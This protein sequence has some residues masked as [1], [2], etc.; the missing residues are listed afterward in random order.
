M[1]RICVAVLVGLLG[2]GDD[3][4]PTDASGG[5]A[6]RDGGNFALRG[7]VQK[8]PFVAGSTV[9]VAAVDAMLSPTGAVYRTMTSNDL[10]EF[11]VSVGDAPA[12]RIEG[13]GFYY[14]EATA[15][16]SASRIVL[17]A[18]YVPGADTTQSAHV[19]MIT[20]VTADRISALVRGGMPFDAAVAQAERELREGIDI[21]L[22]SFDPGARGVEMSVTGGDTPGNAYAFAV[23]TVFTH[24]AAAREGGSPDANLQE[25]LNQ[26]T[27]DLADGTLMPTLVAE[28]GEA[29]LEFDASVVERGFA[30]RLSSIGSSAV[31][32]DL[33]EVLDQDRDGIVNA[34]DVCPRAPDP[35]QA[36]A[37]SDGIG[38]AC[39]ECGD[40]A[41][42]DGCIPANPPWLLEPVCV[43]SCEDDAPCGSGEECLSVR[44]A[45][46]D[47]GH[48]FFN[49]EVCGAACDPFDLASCPM[50]ASCQHYNLDMTTDGW[51]CTPSVGDAE[52]GDPCTGTLGLNCGPGLFCA[53]GGGAGGT[54]CEITCSMTSPDCPDDVSCEAVPLGGLPAP[55]GYC[56]RPLTDGESCRFGPV[57]R[58][59]IGTCGPDG[60]CTGGGSTS[61]GPCESPRACIGGV[62]RDLPG[63]GE[64][65]YLTQCR[66]GL[67]CDTT[68]DTCRSPCMRDVDCNET[69]VCRATS[70]C[71]PRQPAGGSCNFSEECVLGTECQGSGTS[72]TD[73]G[74]CTP[75]SGIGCSPRRWC[76][77]SG[78]CTARYGEDEPCT[79]DYQCL[80][81]ACPSGTC[82]SS[83]VRACQFDYEC[84]PGN[85]CSGTDPGGAGTCGPQEAAGS[86][87]RS[88]YECLSL[89]CRGGTCMA[90]SGPCTPRTTTGC[91]SGEYCYTDGTCRE[92][93]ADGGA[94]AGDYHCISGDCNGGVC[95][96][97]M[98]SG[99][100]PGTTIGCPLMQYCAPG[101]LCA[102]QR[103]DGATCMAPHE[104]LTGVCNAMGRCGT[105][106]GGCTPG[107]SAGCM[108]T[109]YCASDSTC[110]PKR[111]DGGPCSFP[112]E[113]TSNMCNGG[114]CG[115]TMMSCTPGTSIGCMAS[116]YCNSALMCA[117]KFPDGGP[118]MFAYQ[119]ISGMC[120]A[121]GTCGAPTASC[122][123]G[124]SIGCMASQYC[125]MDLICHSK[126]PDGAT[127]MAAIQ[128]TSGMCNGSGFCGP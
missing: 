3:D 36:D 99:C 94:C 23:S 50:G 21:T 85:W 31:V 63:V 28:L 118:C 109:E 53:L 126:L 2:C 13:D 35:D 110:R 111:P 128:C 49:Y 114:M 100:T 24:A 34:D 46:D 102:A 4:A 71:G 20:H 88:D 37:D 44:V 119:C 11:E 93:R 104:C 18:L 40:L 124:T 17:R 14:N 69:E 101:G 68:T 60:L 122:T 15:E 22:A 1:S 41:C 59:C 90:S 47:A 121:M 33:D 66:F 67:N 98:S 86:A 112:Y 54:R 30:Q 113:C 78:E 7:S 91:V 64:P 82:D 32:P 39:D 76:N 8:G 81:G 84:A 45:N 73:M 12:V 83:I 75:N 116:Q 108:P 9:E 42:P 27:L 87:C 29:M 55:Y 97:P 123:P 56:N 43:R 107:T 92:Q 65:C 5:D 6:P 96:P 25:L 127:C 51:F 70:A 19:N 58:P 74:A 103:A 61:C 105:S 72:C 38:D 117:S 106:T 95:G 10:G 120:N 57:T 16:L 77:A 26:A 115:A 125:G 52:A 48:K 89:N 80:G 62:C 79:N